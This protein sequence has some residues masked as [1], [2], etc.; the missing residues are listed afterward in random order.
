MDMRRECTMQLLIRPQFYIAKRRENKKKMW[1]Y[2]GRE[3]ARREETAVT[4]S[5]DIKCETWNCGTKHA[6]TTDL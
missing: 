6:N 2:M 4:H 5:L 1:L 3:K